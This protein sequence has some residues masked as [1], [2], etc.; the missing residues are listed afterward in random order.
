MS[1]GRVSF[2]RAHSKRA[3]RTKSLEGSEKYL[4]D[5]QSFGAKQLEL[6]PLLV[7]NPKWA[8][9]TKTNLF[10]ALVAQTKLQKAT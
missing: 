10:I 2:S 6:F 9:K 5:Y 3:F 4:F 8:E 1:V 7:S